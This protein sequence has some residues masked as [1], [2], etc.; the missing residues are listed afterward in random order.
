MPCQDVLA[1]HEISQ[2]SKG[3]SVTFLFKQ[4]VLTEFLLVPYVKA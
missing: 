4:T 3:Y 2:Y 1:L